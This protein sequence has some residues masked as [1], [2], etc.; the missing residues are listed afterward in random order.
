MSIS[1]ADRQA[2]VDG[3]VGVTTQSG[4]TAFGRLQRVPEHDVPGRG[5]D[6][7]GPGLRQGPHRRVRGVRTGP[8]PALRRVGLH[9]GVR[10]R[11]LGRRAVARRLFD[12]LSGTQPLPPAPAGGQVTDLTDPLA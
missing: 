11:R 1:P 12:V 3:M 2:I 9:G 5:E 8:G 7:Y 10:L 4:G 6:G